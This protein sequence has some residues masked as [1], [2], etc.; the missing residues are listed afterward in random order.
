MK[1]IFRAKV[2]SSFLLSMFV[3]LVSFAVMLAVLELEAVF[4]MGHPLIPGV[5]WAIVLFLLSPAVSLIAVTLIVRNS[6][7]AQSVEESQQSAVFLI[8]PAILLVVGQFAGVMLLNVWI[9]LGLGVLCAALAWMLLQRAVRRFTYE[10][11]LK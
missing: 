5:G 4:L 10:M 6:A 2:L 9:L 8:I 7:K 11:L 3:S 1:E